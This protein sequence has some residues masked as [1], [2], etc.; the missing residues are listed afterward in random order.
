MTWFVCIDAGGS[1]SR[2]ALFRRNNEKIEVTV[3]GMPISLRLGASVAFN[4]MMDLLSTLSDSSSISVDEI[5]SVCIG[6]AGTEC[7]SAAR[8][9][10][11]LCPQSKKWL[12][13]S[14]GIGHLIGAF[15]G[16]PGACIAVGTGVILEGIDNDGR[17]FRRGGW[18][19]PFG[20]RGGGAWMGAELIW[21]LMS[22]MDAGD[23]ESIE[24][25]IRS[26]ISLNRS[27][28]IQWTASAGAADFAE[29]ARTVF[30]MADAGDECAKRII[31]R[32]VAEIDSLAKTVPSKL[33]VCLTGGVGLR[34]MDYSNN[35]YFRPKHSAIWGLRRMQLGLVDNR[36]R[37]VG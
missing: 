1:G 26:T 37:E 25:P 33:P 34:L 13:V 19:F 22:H 36:H 4:R 27:E 17:F 21:L 29:L 32:A 5:S 16:A 2:A 35:K 30:K 9:F 20:D 7:V 8:T 31:L 6:L 24:L 11:E 10:R 15:C 28:L 12:I 3:T 23:L 14:D 18:G